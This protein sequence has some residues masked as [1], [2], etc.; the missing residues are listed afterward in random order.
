MQYTALSALG[1]PGLVH[2]FFAKEEFIPPP[3]PEI[4]VV[5]PVD[6]VPGGYYRR[7]YPIRVPERSWVDEDDE[8]L[9][10]ASL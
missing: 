3:E 9:I 5:I 1:T 7:V 6:V 10:L 2:S 8:V 4:P